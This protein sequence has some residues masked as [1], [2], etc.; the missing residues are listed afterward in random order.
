MGGSYWTNQGPNHGDQASSC[1]LP[2][3]F[4]TAYSSS[5]ISFHWFGCGSEGDFEYGSAFSF[6]YANGDGTETSGVGSNDYGY[7][8]GYL[9][10]DNGSGCCDVYYDGNGGYYVSDTCGGGE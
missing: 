9:I 4:Y 1:W 10:Y 6:I 3:Y 8:S 7:Y 5:G 2:A